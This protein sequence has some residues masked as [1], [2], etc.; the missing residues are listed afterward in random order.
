MLQSSNKYASTAAVLTEFL[1][2]LDTLGDL[3]DQYGHDA[4]GQQYNALPGAVKAGFVKMGTTEYT[5]TIGATLDAS[6]MTVIETVHDDNG[7]PK[8]TVLQCVHPGLELQGNVIRSCLVVASLG[9]PLP[10]QDD[11]GDNETMDEAEP[12]PETTAT[13]NDAAEAAP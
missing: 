3:R 13:S 8:D 10:E 2:V 1:P 9:A 5:A 6:R 4:F 7:A 11:D 12:S